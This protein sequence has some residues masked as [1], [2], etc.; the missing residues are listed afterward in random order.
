[1]NAPLDHASSGNHK[2]E[3]NPERTQQMII[4]AAK[5]NQ[6]KKQWDPQFCQEAVSAYTQHLQYLLELKQKHN[7]NSSSPSSS[8][9]DSDHHY[10]IPKEALTTILSSQ[11]TEKA[12]KAM[13]K[14]NLDTHLL[15][16]QV[17]HVERLIGTIN[18]TPLT[19]TLSLHLL[20]ANGKAGNVGRTISL[21]HLRGKK[22]YRPTR[23]EYQFAIRAIHAAG[24]YLRKNRNV[25][26]Q[27]DQ[28]PE[29]DNPTRWLDA[30]LVNMSER[31]V[32]LDTIMANQ[33]LDC[34]CSTGRSGKAIHFFYRVTRQYIDEHGKDA[35]DDDDDTGDAISASEHR[36]PDKIVEKMPVFEDR[37]TKVRMRMR[38]HMPPYYK[39][40][41]DVKLNGELV[42]RPSK[43]ELIPKLEW[44]KVRFVLFMSFDTCG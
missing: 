40:P 18:L 34:Y 31:G 7:N 20:E 32:Q 3:Y 41:S 38:Q 27:E 30:I 21:L 10:G 4:Q 6:G 14:M 8:P 13:T 42:K 12:L 25:F 23:K 22:K 16:K 37:K 35:K 9:S 44:E 29:I 19:N 2:F 1:M 33:M 43:E 39:I 28:Q 11:T 36:I 24:L 5:W 26:L 17:R 15:S